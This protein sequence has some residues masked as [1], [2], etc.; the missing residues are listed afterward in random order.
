MSEQ[1]IL[2]FSLLLFRFRSVSFFCVFF[3]FV[4]LFLSLSLSSFV[5]LWHISN[6]NMLIFAVRMQFKFGQPMRVICSKNYERCWLCTRSPKIPKTIKHFLWN[7][8]KNGIFPWI[9]VVLILVQCIWDNWTGETSNNNK[10]NLGKSL[11]DRYKVGTL[12][13]SSRLIA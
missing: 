9:I 13:C 7:R 2:C 5:F 4:V 6:E 12:T 8:K 1:S 10:N 3:L 11:M